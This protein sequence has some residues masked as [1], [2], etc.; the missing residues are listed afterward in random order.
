MN[1]EATL[2][3]AISL[4]LFLSV[5][6]T[7]YCLTH[8]Q[9]T[10]SER[11]NTQSL[12]LRYGALNSLTLFFSEFF[13]SFNLFWST[14][15]C[16]TIRQSKD[17]SFT[18]NITAEDRVDIQ[19]PF[20]LATASETQSTEVIENKMKTNAISSASN[21]RFFFFFFCTNSSHQYF[22]IN[23]ERTEQEKT[24]NFTFFGK[25]EIF[26]WKNKWNLAMY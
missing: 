18:Y 24:A 26:N 14:I 2:S 16:G 20:E 21:S 5:S 6:H 13:F 15:L 25:T 8:R 23:S 11:S 1:I 22:D 17:F 7:H 4:S 10:E 19:C 9:N 3:V 12:Y